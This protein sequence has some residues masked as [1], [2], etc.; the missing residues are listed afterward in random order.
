MIKKTMPKLTTRQENYSEWYNQIVQQAELAESSSVRWCMVI[1][2]Y[3]FAIRENMR[4]VLDVMFKKT[5]HSNAYFPLFIPKS[6]L[7]K[8][9]NHVEWFAKECAIV[10]HYRL[11]NN[12]NWKWVIVDPEAKLDEELIV[13]PTS[14]TIIWDSY[15][16]WI[17]SYRD[18]PLLINQR[19]NVVRREM[20]TRTFLRT[21]EFLRQ[22][23]HTAHSTA[24]EADE[25]AKRMID[26]YRDF[27]E[28]FMG[29]SP[30][31]WIKPEHDKFAWA[32]TTYTYEPMM[33]DFK[34]LQAGT[35]HFLGQN[36]GKAFDVTFTN[37]DNKQENVRWT[38]RWVS[39]RMMWW[40][41]MAH[42]DDSGLVLP[43]N[44][45]P[46]H[47]IIVPIFK[48]K[49]DLE[50]I[51]EFLKPITDGLEN[52][53]FSTD[54]K[55][56][57]NKI[58]VERKI[59]DD[60][61]KWPGWKFNEREMKGAPLRITVWPKDLERWE[62]EIF[63]RL[64]WEKSFLSPDEL[65]AGI[66]WKLESIQKTMLSNNKKFR[67]KN[68]YLVDTYEDF[69]DKVQKG[70][71]YAHRDWTAE[72]AEKIQKETQATIRCIP[73]PDF[74]EDKNIGKCIITWNESKWRVLFAKSY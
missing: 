21:T 41:I 39:T 33:Q 64:G 58:K 71:V 1:K 28:N 18:L 46:L 35:S 49:E 8:E 48:T 16:K 34:A 57:A 29:I 14:E 74:M 25:E 19:A 38:S 66:S 13:R 60:E 52:M 55:Y 2:P 67:E 59:D 9:A 56:F 72:T 50:K 17:N 47:V 6:F 30:V 12:P 31:M 42:S 27:S 11:K 24:E 73:N 65:V 51:K 10:T 3:W 5:G 68:S 23:W 20:R 69:K 26:V 4:N 53:F 44:L 61:N 32:E 40:L 37:K 36:F 7:S 54:S 45:A 63:E 22:E 70:F 15:K 62:V 43:P